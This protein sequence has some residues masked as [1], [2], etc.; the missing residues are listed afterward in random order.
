MPGVDPRPSPE[1]SAD[2]PEDAVA[3]RDPAGAAADARI[4]R[5][6]AELGTTEVGRWAD[7]V[8]DRAGVQVVYGS[9][10]ADR[11]LPARRTLRLDVG[12]TDAEQ[13]VAL[14]HGAIHVDT[15]HARDTPGG[16]RERMLLP[17]AE[18]VGRMLDEET[19]AHALEIVARLQLRAAGH[20]LPVTDLERAYTRAFDAAR[21]AAVREHPD[22][23]AHDLDRR[24]NEAGLRA[25]RPLVA[26]LPADPTGITYGEA[27][28]ADWDRAHGIRP[29]DALVRTALAAGEVS[30]QIRHEGTSVNSARRVEL[31]T[32]ADGT[33]LIRKTMINSRHADAEQLFSALARAVGA[34]VPEVFRAGRNVV[35]LRRTNSARWTPTRAARSAWPTRWPGCP[36]AMRAAG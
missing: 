28:G 16:A 13:M 14:V 34:P 11:Y 1:G 36:T 27:Y 7:D 18:Y 30:A 15:A 31:V 26:D 12:A 25:L 24:A 35:Y 29:F 23:P 2:R 5:V 4:A 9:D 33:Q 21:A 20:D 22:A 19:R 6:R 3:P 32:F 8:L 17:R 10:G